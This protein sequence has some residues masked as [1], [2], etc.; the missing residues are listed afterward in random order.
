MHRRPVN[1]RIPIQGHGSVA[2]M[3]IQLPISV[4]VVRNFREPLM[5]PFHIYTNSSYK[6]SSEEAIVAKIYRLERVL[7]KLKEAFLSVLLTTKS[8]SGRVMLCTQ[9]K[10]V[11]TAKKSY[12]WIRRVA[13]SIELLKRARR[14]VFDS[15]GGRTK[16]YSRNV[17]RYGVRYCVHQC[18]IEY[19]Y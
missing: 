1:S 13:F 2:S 14:V 12:T 6:H 8:S 7:E 3:A 5:N 11:A 17:P 9:P 19:S 18:G 15:S 4:N 16:T 10:T